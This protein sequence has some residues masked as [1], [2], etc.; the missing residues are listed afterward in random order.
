MAPALLETTDIAVNGKNGVDE[1]KKVGY[2]ANYL[3]SLEPCQFPT[4]NDGLDGESRLK[5]LPF[6]VR[7]G[8]LKLQGHCKVHGVSLANVFQLAWAMVL[9]CYTRTDSVSFG[10]EIGGDPGELHG[11]TVLPLSAKLG[12]ERLTTAEALKYIAA[13]YSLGVKHS[14][15]WTADLE[16]AAASTFYTKVVVHTGPLPED[17]P[18]E[19]QFDVSAVSTGG[20]YQQHS[21]DQSIPC[22]K[23][24]LPCKSPML[25]PKYPPT[26]SSGLRFFP[27]ARQ[28]MSSTLCREQSSASFTIHK[29]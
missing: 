11:G 25:A 24:Q 10:Y 13:D 4:R 28:P 14:N 9:R 12:G 20:L 16:A 29:S 22:R 15:T 7:E 5:Q 3:A 19:Q 23:A 18:D 21:T 1:D 27:K 2:W 6:T 8:A 26:S 17:R